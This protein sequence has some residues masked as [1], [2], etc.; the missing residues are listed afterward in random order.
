MKFFYKVAVQRE[1]MSR[2]AM[3]SFMLWPGVC[4]YI[5]M[6]SLEKPQ[7]SSTPKL[8]LL[9]WICHGISLA[10]SDFGLPL[11]DL[12]F[13]EDFLRILCLEVADEARIP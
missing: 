2:A 3:F 6:S 11:G 1:A 10:E 7:H 12:M 13:H 4:L 5:S 8:G 9:V